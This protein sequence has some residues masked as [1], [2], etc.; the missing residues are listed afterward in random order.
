MAVDSN[1]LPKLIKSVPWTPGLDESG[2]GSV[3]TRVSELVERRSP[4]AQSQ[5]V[6]GITPEATT[7][8][9]EHMLR[10]SGE[11]RLYAQLVNAEGDVRIWKDPSDVQ[12][13]GSITL[14]CSTSGIKLDLLIFIP[15]P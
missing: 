7:F 12:R 10:P 13:P 8:T 14:R 4:F 11:D 9:V 1:L 5:F 6:Y 3:S 2:P 15:R